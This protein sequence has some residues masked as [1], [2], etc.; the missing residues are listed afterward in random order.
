MKT[1]KEASMGRLIRRLLIF[2]W[3]G[4]L[5]GVAGVR[6]Q[7]A[8]TIV[9][10]TLRRADGSVATGMVTVRWNSFTTS[11]GQAVAA[12]QK[13]WKTDANGVLTIPLFPSTAGGYYRV[14]I[15]LDDGETSEE[16]WVVPATAMTTLAG[17]RASVVP[18]TV[19]GQYVSLNYLNAQLSSL[20]PKSYVDAAVTASTASGIETP[21]VN[22][23]Q[24]AVQASGP[25]AC[26]KITAAIAALPS[27]GGVVDARGFQGVQSNCAA[28]LDLSQKPVQ[29]MLDRVTLPLGG[30]LIV[31]P[32]SQIRGAGKTAS[33]T[34]I[35]WTSSALT[36][37]QDA[38]TVY[39]NG[40]D[41]DMTASSLDD[42]F[43]DCAGYG[44]D[45]VRERGGRNW[46]I[47]V[48]IE[49]CARDCLVIGG[50]QAYRWTEQATVDAEVFNFGRYGMRLDTTAGTSTFITHLSFP[51]LHIGD[52]PLGGSN[53]IYVNMGGSGYSS[54]GVQELSFQDLHVMVTMSNATSAI[55]ANCNGGTNSAATW[56]NFY[57][58]EIENASGSSTG[59]IMDASASGCLQGT[60]FHNMWMDSRWGGG[61]ASANVPT[62][63]ILG[64]QY[65]QMAGLNIPLNFGEQWPGPAANHLSD[66]FVQN[67]GGGLQYLFG[68]QEGNIQNG[69]VLMSSARVLNSGA[70]QTGIICPSAWAGSGT[71][72]QWGCIG[73]T[74]DTSNQG[75]K[76]NFL[77]ASTAGGNAAPVPSPNP[78]A[79]LDHLGNFSAN[80]Y[81]VNGTA[82]ASSN[83]SDGASLVKSGADINSSNQVTAT[84][85]ASPLPASQGGTGQN[86]TA[87]Y[88]TSGT[89]ATTA[90]VPAAGSCTNQVEVADNAGN[91][92]TCAKVTSAMVDSTVATTAGTI[93][94]SW[95]VSVSGVWS[96]SGYTGTASPLIPTVSSDQIWDVFLSCYN[97][98]T[99]TAG[100]ATV[101][102]SWTDTYGARS[103]NLINYQAACITTAGGMYGTVVYQLH[104]KSGT[105]VTY[106]LNNNSAA[107]SWSAQVEITARRAQ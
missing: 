20:A 39:W 16:Q 98:T 28:G 6:A 40:T 32:F 82:L 26:A 89:V 94:A 37:T 61:V 91:G 68:G 2:A 99:G 53:P 81:L 77:V 47:N 105:A 73:V 49:N 80:S 15:K 14:L 78:V 23:I 56:W 33:G 25:D 75:P 19:A 29:L 12:D 1:G 5:A 38:V 62:P 60:V 101:T 13:T 4:L 76:W 45:C 69:T 66:I 55:Y 103:N 63:T 57:N 93:P 42:V 34:H 70:P 52:G 102:V 51:H 86:S 46:R 107:G 41:N 31:G 18:T 30:Q 92:P 74:Q 58:G 48:Q 22:G 3:V 67:D 100:A 36:S 90:A 35:T 24:Q 65:S 72:Q 104:V 11:G 54:S 9:Q 27:T 87:V 17:V 79:T 21:S 44:Q 96:G 106:S 83:L 97:L 95:N 84:H 85:L 7:S 8:Q 50:D 64:G 59:Y 43:V 71:L 10:D 88:P